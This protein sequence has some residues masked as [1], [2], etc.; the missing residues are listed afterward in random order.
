MNAADLL[1]LDD[2]G[3]ERN[4]EYAVETVYNVIDSRYRVGKPV[5]VTTNLTLEEMQN[6]T[7]IKCHRIYDRIFEVCYPLRFEGKSMRG[8]EATGR[9]N[10]MKVLLEG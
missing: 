7:D 9:F 2:L 6:S 8:K 5:I 1:I 3:A 4:T 10:E